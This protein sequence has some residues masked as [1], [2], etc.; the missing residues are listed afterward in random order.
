MKKLIQ[1]IRSLDKIPKYF[2]FVFV[3]GSTWSLLEAWNWD[4]IF[5][6][7]GLVGLF[8]YWLLFSF[9]SNNNK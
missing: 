6:V 4:G 3:T 7:S 9:K 2:M 1:Y 5:F 8:F